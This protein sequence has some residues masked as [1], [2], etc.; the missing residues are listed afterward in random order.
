MNLNK[1][2][3]AISTMLYGLLFSSVAIFYLILTIVSSYKETNNNSINNIRDKLAST[4]VLTRAVD[5]ETSIKNYSNTKVVISSLEEKQLEIT[6]TNGLNE[7]ILY[8]MY[9]VV[10]K[11][12][13]DV[14][15]TLVTDNL[16]GTLNGSKSLVL[17]LYNKD[18]DYTIIE[19]YT[20]GAYLSEEISLKDN[21][22]PI[23][24]DKTP[25][26]ITNLKDAGQGKIT[27]T[28]NDLESRVDKYCVN[29]SATN[30][31]N[32]NWLD[33]INGTQTTG[34]IATSSGSYY[35]HVKDLAGNIA[36]SNQVNMVLKH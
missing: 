12:N 35:V 15:A 29:S 24:L 21:E 5:I 3:V 36:N 25:P 10:Q 18:S 20:K 33:A 9:Y 28:A 31:S 7:N 19:I 6:L 17:N 23:T 4:T 30:I 34:V 1:K 27:F 32:C 22:L 2:G 13:G 14:I 26:S 16:K 8:Q 11:G